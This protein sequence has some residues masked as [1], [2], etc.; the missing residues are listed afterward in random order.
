MKCVRI[1]LVLIC[2]YN[3]WWKYKVSIIYHCKVELHLLVKLNNNY[4]K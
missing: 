1:W 3:I 4:L 2:G